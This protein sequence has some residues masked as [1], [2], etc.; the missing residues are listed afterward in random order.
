ML[1]QFLE[2]E[3]DCTGHLLTAENEISFDITARTADG[4]LKG[5]FFVRLDT[6]E[7]GDGFIYSHSAPTKYSAATSAPR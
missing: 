4:W 7:P 5:A 1:G 2:L 3:C 6:Q